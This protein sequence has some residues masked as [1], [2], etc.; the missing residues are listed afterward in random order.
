MGADYRERERENSARHLSSR[1][2]SDVILESGFPSAFRSTTVVSILP[3]SQLSFIFHAGDV[4]QPLSCFSTLFNSLVVTNYYKLE[5]IE[6]NQ[7]NISAFHASIR[8]KFEEL[9]IKLLSAARS[10]E[11]RSRHLLE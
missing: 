11:K 9:R 10:C 4:S 6:I 7:I 2:I 1:F 3:F 8:Q 5:Q